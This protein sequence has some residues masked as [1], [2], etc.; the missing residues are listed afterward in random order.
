MVK[1]FRILE[2]MEPG[3]GVSLNEITQATKLNKGTVCNILKTLVHVGYVEKTKAGHYR[4]T[5]KILTLSRP[6]TQE[7]AIRAFCEKFAQ[8]LAEETSESGVVT[9]LRENKVCILAQAQHQRRVMISISNY[10]D[11]SLFHSVSGR[12]LLSH[13]DVSELALICESVGFPGDEWNRICTMAAL[14]RATSVIRREGVATME[15]PNDEISSYAVPVFDAF[16]KICAA[17]GF[18]VPIFRL[19]EL[20]K[21]RHLQVLRANA[22]E[23][24]EALAAR[25]FQQEDFM[26]RLQETS[27]RNKNPQSAKF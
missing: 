12:I 2:R 9:T 14:L 21:Q 7:D 4:I 3:E 15:N 17:I 1:V 8:R 11:L 25:H 27:L 6:L 24:S 20:S 18:S 22:R 23:M 5:R 26:S 19:D 16:G 10:K 13:L